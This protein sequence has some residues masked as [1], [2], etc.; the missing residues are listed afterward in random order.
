M[1]ATGIECSYPTLEGGGWRMDQMA[2]C[3]H[4]RRW[5]ADLGL[6]RDLGLRYL[7][8]GPPLHLIHQ[9]PGQYDW[10]FLD[11][12]AA[13][14]QRLG[15]VPIM[16]LCH[17]GLPD[18]LQNFQ[19]PEVPHALAD[20]ATAF[21]RRYP[22]VRLYTPVN[23]MY[24][25]AKLSALE[26]VRNEQLKSERAFVTALKHL[27]KASVLATQVIARERPDAVFVNSE[28]SEFFQ[29][30]CPDDKTLEIAA[31]ENERR[32]IS[33][34]LIYGVRTG[35]RIRR[36][37]SEQGMTSSEYDWFMNQRT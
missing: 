7:R 37:L 22:W 8:Y 35:P 28:S 25:T 31:F 32:F 15:I 36:Y 14:M 5:R 34:D 1:S 24:V 17:F 23:E 3:D 13:E 4:Y 30:C 26:R 12:V 20:Y 9:G 2:A 21:A 29:P 16:D 10:A 33:L 18:W 6:V 11:E 27:A 19:N